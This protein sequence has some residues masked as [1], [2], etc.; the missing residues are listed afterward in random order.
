MCS[1]ARYRKKLISFCEDAARE[2]GLGVV[3]IY[4]YEKMADNLSIYPKLGYSEVGRRPE[5]GFNRVYFEKVLYWRTTAL[6]RLWPL[7][8]K[9]R[10]HR[11]VITGLFP[12]AHGPQDAA[13]MGGAGDVRGGPDVI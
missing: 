8:V 7:Q 11:D 2:Q 4:T 6:S 5:D 10:Q 1:W 12:A 13:A 9:R 3:Q